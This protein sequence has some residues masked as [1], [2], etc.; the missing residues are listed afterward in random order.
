MREAF[1]G[2]WALPGDDGVAKLRTMMKQLSIAAVLVL[3]VGCKVEGSSSPPAKDDTKSAKVE[4]KPATPRPQLPAVSPDQPANQAAQPQAASEETLDT[5]PKSYPVV[6]MEVP[7]V[8]DTDIIRP[9]EDQYRGRNVWRKRRH[10]DTDHDGKVSEAELAADSQKRMESA[11][12]RLDLDGDGVLTADEVQS[13]SG[14]LRFDNAA[15]LDTNRDGDISA[16]ELTAGLRARRGDTRPVTPSA[17]AAPKAP[18]PPAP[19]EPA[20]EPATGW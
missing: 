2:S 15:S 12:N 11:K 13:A 3:A 8:N 10:L 1:A 17:P 4:T 19:A 6:Q 14:R 18:P 16:D 9:D 7:T 5:G 20:E